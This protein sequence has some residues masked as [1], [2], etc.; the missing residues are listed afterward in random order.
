VEL[1]GGNENFSGEGRRSNRWGAEP[2]LPL[3]KVSEKSI[4][5]EKYEQTKVDRRARHR[6]AFIDLRTR[7]IE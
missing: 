2:C 4:N 1:T 6:L 3:I 5:M 7:A